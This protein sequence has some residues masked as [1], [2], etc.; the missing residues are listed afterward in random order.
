MAATVKRIWSMFSL[1]V[2]AEGSCTASRPPAFCGFDLVVQTG[3]GAVDQRLELI[4]VAPLDR[5]VGG[6]TAQL[7]D[8]RGPR[9]DAR[10]IGLEI[11]RLA[12]EQVAASA[13]LDLA[14]AVVKL[15]DRRRARGR[16]AR[17]T[18]SARKATGRSDTSCPE[19]NHRR[20]GDGER[21][22]DL[23]FDFHQEQRPRALARATRRTGCRP[24][25]KRARARIWPDDAA[26]LP[27]GP[28]FALVC[29]CVLPRP[30]V[31]IIA[32]W[33]LMMGAARARG[34]VPARANSCPCR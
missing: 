12:G 15:V 1:S 16:C 3:D 2:G 7:G 23:M 21:G 30:A 8:L 18:R 19:Q 17:P 31:G 9:V 24:V 20:H 4:D 34:T 32:F 5:V 10:L 6:Q 29:G 27:G 25:N 26:H 28:G 13:A 14:D 22:D 33:L 11:I